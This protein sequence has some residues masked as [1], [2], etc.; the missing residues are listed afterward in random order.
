MKSLAVVVICLIQVVLIPRSHCRVF[1]PM[2]LKLIEQTCSKTPHR[3]LCVSGLTS[4]P[5]SADADVKG[6]AL[7]M[8]D[9]VLRAV[10]ND[11]RN[12]I[13]EKL[14]HSPED[15]ALSSC[16]ENYRAIV[17]LDI[18]EAYTSITERDPKLA[19]QGMDATI[20]DANACE[21]GFAGKSPLTYVNTLVIDIAAVANAILH[22][23][24]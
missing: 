23:L 14:K 7:I 21:S 3:D 18:I 19:K 17:E 2:D 20:Y 11:T 4:V 12:Q 10:A 15:K 8:V 5:A 9:N 13:N 16:E 6:L 22:L 1:L 24:P